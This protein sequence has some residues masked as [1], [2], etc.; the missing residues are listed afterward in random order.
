[1]G[2]A[3]QEGSSIVACYKPYIKRH[4]FP[5]VR[6]SFW[7]LAWANGCLYNCTYCWLKAYHPWPWNE[8]HVADKTSLTRV[9]KRFCAKTPG[10]QLLNAGE[11]C[12][13]F[14]APE[15]I[16]FMA[17][18]LREANHGYTRGHRLLLLT[19]SADPRVLL[20]NDLQDLIVYSASVNTEAVARDLEKGAP[21]PAER[22]LAARRVKE[23]GYEVRI[24]VDPIIAGSNPAVHAL[25][26][27]ICSTVEPGLITLGSLRATPRTYRFLP[28]SFKAQLAEKTPWGRGYPLETRLGTYSAL[29]DIGRDHDVPMALCKEP[30]DVWRSLKILGKC[31]CIP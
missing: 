13:S 28:E 9:L 20:E 23:A 29:I 3:E 12:D 11:L 5:Q 14:V 7:L 25:I 19:K 31:N 2:D 27:E 15:Y 8:I 10:S 26:E 16:S 21:S 18:T 6:C 30:I 1:M 24:R 4:S 17:S 22:I